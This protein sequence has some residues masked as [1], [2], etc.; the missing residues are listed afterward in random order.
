MLQPS[1]N[2]GR[3]AGPPLSGGRFLTTRE[4]NNSNGITRSAVSR[5]TVRG[6]AGVSTFRIGGNLLAYSGWWPRSTPRLTLRLTLLPSV[7]TIDPL[8][9][10]RSPL[11]AS[12]NASLDAPLEAIN[13][14][15]RSNVSHNAS[16]K[17]FAQ[18]P[19]LNPSFQ[20]FATQIPS[21]Q[22]YTYIHG[23]PLSG[24]PNA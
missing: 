14:A 1:K 9:R 13:L 23:I 3:E 17:R 16:L 11:N 20:P 18:H 10:M 12:L 22:R 4:P 5:L 7:R 24:P 8:P 15:P 19:P 21:A 2:I 6:W